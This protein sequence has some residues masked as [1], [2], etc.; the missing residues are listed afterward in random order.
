MPGGVLKESCL[1]SDCSRSSFLFPHLVQGEGPLEGPVPDDHRDVVDAGLPQH[2]MHLVRGEARNI[3]TIDLQNLVTE[4]KIIHNL[5]NPF[6][7]G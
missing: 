1:W 2:V 3:F 7:G 4:S 5:L 6:K